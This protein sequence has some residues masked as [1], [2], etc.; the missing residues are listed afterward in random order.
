[1]LFGEI[2][3][4][5]DQGLIEVNISYFVMSNADFLKY[6]IQSWLTS[7]IYIVKMNTY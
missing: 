1:M 2:L 7:N 4:S 3:D 6:F 5:F